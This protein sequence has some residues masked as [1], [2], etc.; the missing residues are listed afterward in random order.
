MLLPFAMVWIGKLKTG[1]DWTRLRD[2]DCVWLIGF[3]RT[4]LTIAINGTYDGE[5]APATA[6]S[7]V[8]IR[9]TMT[10]RIGFF[11]FFFE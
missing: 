7:K 3:A 10:L 8:A 6:R 11:F 1:V 5:E 9:A 2:W 4:W